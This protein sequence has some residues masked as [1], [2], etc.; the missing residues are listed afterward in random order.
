MQLS[1]QINGSNHKTCVKG[2]RFA[3]NGK[4]KDNET[5][6]EGN[7]YD[8]GARIYSARLGRWLSVDPAFREFPFCS[9]Y[10]FALNKPLFFIDPDGRKISPSKQFEK[11]SY[12]IVLLQVTTHIEKLPTFNKYLQPFISGGK[13]MKLDFF[14]FGNVYE[15]DDEEVN[16]NDKKGHTTSLPNSNVS[17]VDFNSSA[18]FLLSKNQD[19]K[20]YK[21]GYEMTEAGMVT[22]MVHEFLHAS[23]IHSHTEMMSSRGH[24]KTA[25]LE[26]NKSVGGRLKIDDKQAETLSWV[27]LE[28]T[29]LWK[30]TFDTKE[31]KEQYQN[32][33]TKLLYETK[34]TEMKSEDY[35]KLV[36]STSEEER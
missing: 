4:E 31:K 10:T 2:Y 8:F 5:Y 22:I 25:I 11:S 15:S 3:F 18:T 30:T 34:T 19:T 13:D 35:N 26:Y 7:A 9:P 28:D 33:V 14:F 17:L 16:W 12:N 20:G 23:G 29:E 21:N 6:G 27:G 24:I 36:D 32:D 1:L